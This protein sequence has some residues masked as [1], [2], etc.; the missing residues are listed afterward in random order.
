[1]LRLSTPIR[2][3]RV[4]LSL[5]RS[6]FG[7]YKAESMTRLSEHQLG[8]LLAYLNGEKDGD[9]LAII[10]VIALMLPTMKMRE[11][12]SIR[13]VLPHKLITI[14][15]SD[16]EVPATRSLGRHFILFRD[17]FTE[18]ENE[19]VIGVPY[20]SRVVRNVI[21]ALNWTSVRGDG[22]RL[23]SCMDCIRHFNPILNTF[24]LLFSTQD[25]P[26]SLLL[27]ILPN[28]TEKEIKELLL[29]GS[30]NYIGLTFPGNGMDVSL[31]AAAQTVRS[32]RALCMELFRDTYPSWLFCYIELND[33]SIRYPA[34][35]TDL[36]DLILTAD[37]TKDSSTSQSYM[38]PTVAAYITN[39]LKTTT[40]QLTW[41][42]IAR[43]LAMLGIISS[44]LKNDELNVCAPYGIGNSKSSTW[45][46]TPETLTYMGSV[47]PGT[48]KDT[49]LFEAIKLSHYVDLPTEP[50][51]H[52]HGNTNITIVGTG[53]A[54]NP[55]I[56]NGNTQVLP[57]V[58]RRG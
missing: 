39:S 1:M 4:S 52:E 18:Y 56:I 30:T 9:I 29:V 23:V 34:R 22:P 50:L 27:S 5:V 13:G 49:Y 33:H 15:C 16:G 11:A 3:T 24:P 21:D 6:A 53:S 41:S 43:L 55:W 54:A 10:E 48:W 19:T 14:K 35:G 20:S 58:N 12:M 25:A 36:F 32:N 47:Y 8:E 38:W 44:E 42:E 57:N 31:L 51:L 26:A 2:E 7:L 17:F 46:P 28:F 40:L 37:F 45:S